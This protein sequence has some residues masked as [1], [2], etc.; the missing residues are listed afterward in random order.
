MTEEPRGP[1]SWLSSPVFQW[2]LVGIGVVF[3]GT[4]GLA[5]G[6]RSAV[7][8]WP[9]EQRPPVAAKLETAV[10]TPVVLPAAPELDPASVVRGVINPTSEST[11]A[12]KMTAR[13]TAMPFREGQSFAAGAVLARFDCSQIHAT[14]NAAEAAA[15][16]YRKTY[17]TN[18]E[19]DQFEAVGK[20]EVAV[21]KANLGKAQ[22]EAAAVSS[23]LTDCEVRA[24]F[25]G[26]VVEQI[27]HVKE[28]AASGQP[29]LKIHSGRDVE[30]ELIVPSKWL[31]WLRPGAAF[32]F[33]VDETGNTLR[34]R[35]TRF[36]ASVDPVS[37]T[38]RV[39]GIVTQ[40]SGLV[41]AGMSGTAEF[42]DPRAKPD[43]AAALPPLPGTPPVATTAAPGQTGVD[44]KPS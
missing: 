5:I 3:A 29:L 19:L 31:T 26:K 9:D 33:K 44:G 15:A 18:V 21:S 24:P 25:A 41:L 37:K 35:I 43:R 34:G 39:N 36:G 16:A 28:I 7:S 23:Q 20:N 40:A 10:A 42:D 8:E 6:N 32:S 4:A 17:E 13:I 14:L 12:S 27:G 38:I 22:A 11:I 30:M 2:G 1:K